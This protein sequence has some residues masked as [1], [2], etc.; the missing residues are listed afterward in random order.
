M[1][2]AGPRPRGRVLRRAAGGV[3]LLVVA[4]AALVGGTLLHV[5]VATGRRLVARSVTAVLEQVFTGR[6]VVEKIGSIDSEGFDG[7][8]AT[9]YDPEDAY[10]SSR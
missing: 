8:E 6:V 2:T 7:A 1:D 5:R 3:G 4:S 9:V 10:A